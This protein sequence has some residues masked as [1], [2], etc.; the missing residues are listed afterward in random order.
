MHNTPGIRLGT[1]A[2]FSIEEGV[3]VRRIGF[4][5]IPVCLVYF[6]C[7]PEDTRSL[8]PV[9]RAMV[10][11]ELKAHGIS[12]EAVDFVPTIGAEGRTKRSK[13]TDENPSSESCG[14]NKMGQ[15]YRCWFEIKKGW[16]NRFEW[17]SHRNGK[18]KQQNRC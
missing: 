13:F 18:M 15:Y 6:Y 17:T 2:P 12:D 10:Y 4:A 14:K 5:D 3:R 16:L 1:T 9:L 7:K 8:V 11:H